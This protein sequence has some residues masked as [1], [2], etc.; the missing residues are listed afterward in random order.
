LTQIK[1]RSARALGLVDQ[2]QATM[3]DIPRLL[4]GAGV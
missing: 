4:E 1:S 2:S 3:G